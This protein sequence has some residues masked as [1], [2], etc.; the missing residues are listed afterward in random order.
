[1]KKFKDISEFE[2][3][4]KDKLQGH[5]TPAPPDVWSSVAASTTQSAGILSQA[6]SYLSSATN[7]LK[8]ALFAGGI[9]AVGIVVYNENK[10]TAPSPITQIE[11][12]AQDTAPRQ[13]EDLAPVVQE[14][15][16][17]KPTDNITIAE[18][19]TT[20]KNTKI[21]QKKT[22]AKAETTP[23]AAEKS[24]RND[25]STQPKDTK[26][27]E[28]IKSNEVETRPSSFNISNTKPCK[29]ESVTISQP[30]KTNWT[31]NDK[32]V[33]SNT[34]KYTFTTDNVGLYVISNG[35][36]TKT[37]EVSQLDLKVTIKETERG[38]YL[39]SLPPSLIGNWYMN[40]KLIATNET[41][42]NFE[43]QEVGQHK[44]RTTAVN[45]VCN[46]STT[47]LV[48]LEPI[49]DITFYTIFT[50][51]G[52]GK[53]DEYKVDISEYDNYSIQIY[54]KQNQ[55]VFIS[56][57][58]DIKWNG[59]IYNQ[60]EEC[61]EGEYYAKISYKLKGESPKIKSIRLTLKR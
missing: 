26:Q 60:G 1:M 8:V 18:E 21:A 24:E 23:A 54:N 13:N 53:N 10:S 34:S 15:V 9:A 43:I 4:L 16:A 5:S 38:Q 30:K 20:A 55:R 33:A 40:D 29:G 6:T 46:S 37:I 7:V 42:V 56:Q 59:K 28:D 14:T 61:T 36:T 17:D 44:I 49:G 12:T 25:T 45:H 35:K 52:D 22:V 31:I 39:A 57:D 48:T 2:D 27:E 41:S 47:N 32:K 50:P 19:T 51:D 58:P 3:L 11:D